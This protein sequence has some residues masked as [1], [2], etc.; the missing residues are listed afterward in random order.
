VYDLTE[1][2]EKVIGKPLIAGGIVFFTTFK[3]TSGDACQPGG[4]A[5]LYAFDY[6]CQAFP[7]GFNPI[8]D[9]S[10]CSATFAAS[11]ATSDSPLFGVQVDLGA[12]VPSQPV[13]DSS[14]SFLTIQLSNARFKTIGVNLLEKMAQIQGWQ[15]KEK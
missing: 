13:L 4:S 9:V 15:E 12:G 5:Y 1:P 10:L 7:V 3:P 2:G 14:G 6:M 11:T 8:K